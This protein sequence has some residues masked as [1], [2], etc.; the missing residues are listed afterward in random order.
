MVCCPPAYCMVLGNADPVPD[1]S[2]L[3]PLIQPWPLPAVRRPTDADLM[4]LLGNVSR[5]CRLREP[6][7]S[8]SLSIAGPII[9]FSQ[10]TCF[11]VLRSHHAI[12][13][14]HPLSTDPRNHAPPLVMRFPRGRLVLCGYSFPNMQT[15]SFAD[16][17]IRQQIDG[18][19]Y[20][21]RWWLCLCPGRWCLTIL[22][23]AWIT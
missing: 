15:F 23:R 1:S 21:S 2:R 12:Q 3:P 10:V 11:L 22:N 17:A 6:V 19:R 14:F 18:P 20:V 4:H 8:E 16:V 13:F 5:R 9:K 7:V